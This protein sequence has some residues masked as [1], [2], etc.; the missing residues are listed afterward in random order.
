MQVDAQHRQP[1]KGRPA[2]KTFGIVWCDDFDQC[3]LWHHLVHLLQEH[4]LAGFL[5]AEIEIQGGLLHGLCFLKQGLDQ[6]HK[7][8]SYA[9]FP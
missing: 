4:L 5:H 2:S 8:R 6:A 9:E 3:S 7:L 1:R